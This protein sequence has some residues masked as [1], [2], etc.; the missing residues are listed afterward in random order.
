MLSLLLWS[1]CVLPPSAA[2]SS[3]SEPTSTVEGTLTCGQILSECDLG[4]TTPDCVQACETRGTSAAQRLHA[5]LVECARDSGCVEQTCV[6]RECDTQIKVCQADGAGGEAGA[7]AGPPAG[8]SP[9][10]P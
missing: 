4:C 1:G 10:S 5:A 8:T 2:P 6:E 3:P 7:D 9:D